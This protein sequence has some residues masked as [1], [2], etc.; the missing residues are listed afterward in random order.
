MKT[1]R[2]FISSLENRLDFDSSVPEQETEP[3]FMDVS[4]AMEVPTRL[5][6][7]AVGLQEVA[8]V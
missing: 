7:S 6:D 3:I 5:L 4:A 1:C 8:N 2:L